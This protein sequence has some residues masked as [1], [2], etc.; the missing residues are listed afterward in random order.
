MVLSCALALAQQPVPTFE[1][2]VNLVLVPVVVGDGHGH[3]I[4]KLTKKNFQLFDRGKPQDISSFTAVERP[5]TSAPDSNSGSNSTVPGGPQSIRSNARSG[6]RHIIYLFDDVNTRFADLVNV[7]EAALR[8]LKKGLAAGDDA[9]IYAFSGNP[10]QEFTS[11]QAKLEAAVGKLRWRAEAGRGGM[12][13]PDVSYYIA[14]LILVKGDTQALAGLMSHTIACAHVKPEFAQTIAMAAANR[15]MIIGAQDTEVG[16]RTVR[17]AIRRLSGMP[18]QRVIVMASPGFFAQTPEA[19]KSTAEVLDLAAKSNVIIS[20]LSARGVILAEEEQ[21]VAAGGGAGRRPPRASSPA[22]LWLQY[23]RE[24]ARANLD[25]MKDLA[26]GTGGV[27][28]RNNNDLRAGFDRVAAAP[29]FSYV[30]GFSPA[31]LKPNGTFHALKVRLPNEK[32]VT[33]EARRGITRSSRTQRTS[34]PPRT[35]TTPCSRGPRSTTFRSCSRP[36]SPSRMRATCRKSRW[37]PR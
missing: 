14:D 29:E 20:G 13:C 8:D 25:V 10:T 11:D 23:R 7:R 28:F 17:R 19:T 33:I 5:E 26:E 2:K 36:G 37:S 34:E 16:L 35:S 1:S 22:T 15:Q 32:G 27:L 3:R 24:S 6:D 12:Q 9:A 30:L 18:G 21:D 31:D 4:G